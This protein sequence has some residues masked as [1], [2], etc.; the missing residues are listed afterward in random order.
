VLA[1]FS[2]MASR[3]SSERAMGEASAAIP[4]WEGE[5]ESEVGELA[6]RRRLALR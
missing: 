6:A 2:V 4:S 1:L 3:S 5:R